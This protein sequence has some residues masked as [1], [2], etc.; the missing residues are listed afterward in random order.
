MI[1]WWWVRHGPTR[2][3]ALA[4][5][6]DVPADLSDTPRLERLA[7]ALPEG[8]PVISSDLARA[9]ATADAIA[10]PR[11]RLPH[12]PAL[13]EIHFGEWEGLT[14]DEIAARDP[15][16]SRRY[17][18]EPGEIAPPGGESWNAAAERVARF[19]AGM[20]ARHR[21]ADI[22]AVAHFGVI[23]TQVRQ[24]LAITPQ[25]AL[26]HRID[27]LSLTRLDW[28]GSR[29]EARMINHHP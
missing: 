1:R 11:P 19:V 5:W 15:A 7:A 2:Q 17:W 9:V 23:L 16:L 24:A 29:W 25:Q 4:G 3:K 28:N 20:N 22:I 6:R 10:G 12:A 21:D 13:R 18:E 26:A 8:A 27:P 14:H